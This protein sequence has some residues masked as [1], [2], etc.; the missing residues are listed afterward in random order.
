MSRWLLAAAAVTV[1][2]GVPAARADAL[3]D[4]HKAVD[5]SDYPTAKTSLAAA[6]EAGT[7]GPAEL[8]DIFKLSGMVDA[9]LGDSHAATTWFAKW[10]SIDPKASLPDGT[11]PK[12]KRPF[13]AALAQAKN[14]GPVEVKSETDDEPPAVTLVIVNDPQKL[15][16]GARVYFRVDKRK[17]Q[18][19]SADLDGN[20]IRVELE[21]GKRLDLRVQAIDEHGNRV[22][23]LGSKD[24]PIV[25]TSSGKTKQ[26]GG[27]EH[28]AKPVPVP[29][30]PREPRSWYAQWWVWGIATVVTTG[31]GGFFAW[32]SHQDVQELD[33]LNANSYAHPWSD[34][35]SV[36]SRARRDLLITDI[37]AGVAGAFAIGTLLLYL[38][39]PDAAPAAQEI[40]ARAV[41]TPIPGGGAVVLGGHF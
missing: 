39:R 29:V 16:V 25:I 21:T 1:L 6:L 30:G 19:L 10:L 35:Q 26:L 8:A 18:A 20:K 31:V 27:D 22:V 41:F 38:T 37:S 24:V 33:S 34:A 2:A 13:D 11:S 5:G 7:A 4:A 32:K 14:H 15:I 17:E 9:A 40:E 3:A 12:L 23:E 36:E 28:P